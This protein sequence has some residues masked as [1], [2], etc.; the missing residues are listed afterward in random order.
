MNSVFEVDD[1]STGIGLLW[2]NSLVSKLPEPCNMYSFN[3]LNVF[4]LHKSSL[5]SSCSFVKLTY[6]RVREV[7]VRVLYP[8][9]LTCN[10][11]FAPLLSHIIV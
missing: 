7:K 1:G 11:C 6:K 4:K 8:D 9:S 2:K 10:S 5:H 3:Y